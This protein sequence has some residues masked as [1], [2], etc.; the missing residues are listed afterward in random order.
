MIE[1]LADFHDPERNLR[2]A[3]G[4]ISIA[5][6]V[7]TDPEPTNVAGRPSALE[8]L[9][10]LEKA[11]YRIERAQR[12]VIDQLRADGMRW[13]EIADALSLTPDQ[14]RARFTTAWLGRGGGS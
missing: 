14:A 12:T 9:E 7:I 13:A 4:R 6:D 5:L 2:S 11:H 1:P 3:T 10:H 8:A